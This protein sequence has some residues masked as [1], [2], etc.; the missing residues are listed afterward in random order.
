MPALRVTLKITG[1]FTGPAGPELHTVDVDRLPAA[2]ADRVRSLV[3]AAKLSAPLQTMLKAQPQSSD[4][5]H[6]LTVEDESGT[7]TVRFHPETA[8][9]EVRALE[10]A[11]KQAH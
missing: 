9:P 4:F 11:V 7:R 3:N 8:T 1:G 10:E 2:D 5:L 6:E